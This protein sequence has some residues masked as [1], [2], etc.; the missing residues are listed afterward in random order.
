MAHPLLLSATMSLSTPPGT[1]RTAALQTHH[2]KMTTTVPSVGVDSYHHLNPSDD[3]NDH[4][5]DDDAH[6]YP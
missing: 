5:P 3:D 4:Y 1:Y 6:A 2:P